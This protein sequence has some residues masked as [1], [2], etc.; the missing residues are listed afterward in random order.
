MQAPVCSPQ[1]Y[2]G[3]MAEK[4][5][6]V[7]VPRPKPPAIADQE[8]CSGNAREEQARRNRLAAVWSSSSAPLLPFELSRCDHQTYMRFNKVSGSEGRNVNAL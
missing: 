3:S 8:G 5:S 1:R 6:A 7:Q 2:E 4:K